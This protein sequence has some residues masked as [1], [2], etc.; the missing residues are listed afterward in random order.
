MYL[1]IDI[2]MDICIFPE[3]LCHTLMLSVGPF[4]LASIHVNIATCSI[5]LL[6]KIEPSYFLCH[7]SKFLFLSANCMQRQK[8]S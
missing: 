7:S 5:Y 3:H 4:L 2:S 8:N 1:S 6:F